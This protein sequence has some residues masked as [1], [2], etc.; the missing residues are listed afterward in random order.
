V[1]FP[2]LKMP[3]PVNAFVLNRTQ[4][5]RLKG[6][7]YGKITMVLP[8]PDK[9]FLNDFLSVFTVFSVTQGEN[10]QIGVK[11]CEQEGKSRTVSLFEF[12]QYRFFIKK[13]HYQFRLILGI[14]MYTVLNYKP[15]T[16]PDM[17]LPRHIRPVL[18]T[19]GGKSIPFVPDFP[20]QYIFPLN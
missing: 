17:D 6:G 13:G 11:G 10:Y 3:Q 15:N 18:M 1:P 7:I 19:T 20:I 12:L 14:Q 9:Y 2:D 8:D 16:S 5:K 4:Q